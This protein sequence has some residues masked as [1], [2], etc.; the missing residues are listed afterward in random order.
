[1]AINFFKNHRNTE[2]NVEHEFSV[3]GVTFFESYIVN[4]QRGISPKEFEDLPD[5]TWFMS[6][7]I[8]NDEVWENIKNGMLNGFSIDISNIDLKEEKEI[9]T[10]EELIKYLNNN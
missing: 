3:N 5:G 6:A 9:D 1:M 10:I 4:K 2:G 8:T 7:K